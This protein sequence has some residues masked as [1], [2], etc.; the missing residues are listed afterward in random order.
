MK[1][2]TFLLLAL[3]GLGFVA[4]SQTHDT[5]VN[6]IALTVNSIDIGCSTSVVKERL[7]E[8]DRLDRINDGPKEIWTYHVSSRDIRVFADTNTVYSIW[9]TEINFGYG[10]S[11]QVGQSMQDVK[12]C[13]GEPYRVEHHSDYDHAPVPPTFV[14]KDPPVQVFFDR[15]NLTSTF[16]VPGP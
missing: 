1:T 12:A 13:L 9:G 5:A 16:A 11:L 8:P 6:P 7:G 3:F 14:Y 4:C 15:Q 2:L 10:R